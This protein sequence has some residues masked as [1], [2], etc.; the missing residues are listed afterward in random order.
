MSDPIKVAGEIQAAINRIAAG[1]RE[2]KIRAI[3]KADTNGKYYKEKAKAIIKLRNGIEMEID[4]LKTTNVSATNA[5]SIARGICYKE[6]IAK[7]L[8]EAEYTN[9]VK[10]MAALIA[11]LNG[12]QSLNRH[13]KEV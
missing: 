4:G 5:E 11:E 3:T 1:R 13:L 8:A 6:K 9:A 10:G 2:F 7:E 12:L